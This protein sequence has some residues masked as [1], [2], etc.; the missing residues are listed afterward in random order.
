[1]VLFPSGSPSSPIR[2]SSPELSRRS[3]F[4][5]EAA[6]ADAALLPALCFP[7]SEV[8]FCFSLPPSPASFLPRKQK[9]G[10]EKQEG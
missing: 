7:L 2:S 3:D 9:T 5:P 10:E 4:P 6:A 1:M 8:L